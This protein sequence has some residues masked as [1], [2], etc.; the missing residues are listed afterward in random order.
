MSTEVATTEY[1]VITHYDE[2]ST[3]ELKWLATT[4][5]ASEEQARDVMALFAAETEKLK[6]RFLLVDTTEFFHRWADDMMAWR[7]REIVPL[8]NAGGVAKFAF[9]TGDGVPFPTVESGAEPAPEGPAAFPTG[10]F[11]SRDRAY[12]WLAETDMAR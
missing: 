7:D 8:Y 2:W 1:G 12:Q 9:V 5:N 4:K 3:L 10:W 6:P 11:A